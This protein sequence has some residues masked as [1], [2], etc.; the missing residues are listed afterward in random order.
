MA[1][2]RFSGACRAAAKFLPRGPLAGGVESVGRLI[3]CNSRN[4]RGGA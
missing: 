3:I 4:F 2:L 1:I